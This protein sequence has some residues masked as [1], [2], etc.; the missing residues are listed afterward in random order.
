MTD[1]LRPVVRAI[2]LLEAFHQRG[3]LATKDVMELF[4]VDR[5]VA[6]R[7]V[8]SLIEAG[9]PIT[10]VGEGNA[11]RNVLDAGYRR[12]RFHF[13]AGDAFAFALARRMMPFLES[14]LVTEWLD[15]LHAKLAVGRPEQT[16]RWEERFRQRLVYLSE[17]HRSYAEHE[18]VIDPL[19]RCLL[20]DK[21]AHLDYAGVRR[22]DKLTV[23]P[24]ALVIYRRALYLLARRA[25]A[26]ELRRFAIERIRSA[27][28]GEPFRYPVGFDPHEAFRESYGIADP[29]HPISEVRLR[30]VKGTAE[31]VRARHFHPTQ[32]FE[33]GPDGTLDLVMTTGG[34][35]LENLALEYGWT[36][37]VIAP[38]WLRATVAEHHRRAAAYYSTDDGR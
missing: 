34:R 33:D 25:G 14:T 15:E 5:Q 3:T 21:T 4:D 12:S 8:L 7:D 10:P 17:P 24:L 6:R 35:E 22:R 11:T 38:A 16:A 29:D 27:R 28:I 18:A 36:V 20:D 1:K 19:I 2:K 23:E 37:E 31:Y 32:R 9:V 26:T 13:T 30:F